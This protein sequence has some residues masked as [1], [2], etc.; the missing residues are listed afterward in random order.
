VRIEINGESFSAFEGESLAVAL[1]V[2]G[3]LVLRHSPGLNQARG[4]FCLMGV[5]QECR[6]QVDGETTPSCME[7]VREGMRVLLEPLKRASPPKDGS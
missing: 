4:M 6:V 2:N 1:A 7:P 3:I 5:C